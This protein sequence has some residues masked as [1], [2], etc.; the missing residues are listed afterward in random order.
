GPERFQGKADPRSDIYGLGLTL[1]ELLTLRPGFPET[2]RNKLMHQVLHD[3]PP[4]PRQFQADI[5]RDLETIVL[6]ASA[7]E[8]AHRYETAAA[9]V[10]DLRRFME[11]RPV[12]ARPVGPVERLWRWSRRNPLV[13]SLAAV[14]AFLLLAGTGTATYFAVQAARQAADALAEKGRAD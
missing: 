1:Y 8:P 6:K 14:I 12:L 4:R 11:D 13:A 10:E 7:K 2:D 5:P 3:E 9:L